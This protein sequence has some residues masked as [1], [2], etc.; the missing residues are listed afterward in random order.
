M[1]VPRRIPPYLWVATLLFVAGIFL[2]N[3]GDVWKR[4]RACQVQPRR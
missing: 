4:K 3:G 1:R 2:D